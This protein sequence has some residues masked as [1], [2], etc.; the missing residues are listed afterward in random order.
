MN[1]TILIEPI[2]HRDVPGYHLAT[3]GSALDAIE[4]VDATCLK[5]MFDFYHMQII[6]ADPVRAFEKY[7]DLIGHVQ[8]AAVPDRGAPDHGELDYVEVL[9]AVRAIGYT[10]FVGAEYRPRGATSDDLAWLAEMRAQ[11][12]EASD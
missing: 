4:H 2:N 1:K 5:I 3:L 6:Q 11:L 7:C 9:G 8:I 10:G 12:G